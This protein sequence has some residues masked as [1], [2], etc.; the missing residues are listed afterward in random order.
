MLDAGIARLFNG[1]TRQFDIVRH[2]AAHTGDLPNA[3]TELV[4]HRTP[5]GMSTTVPLLT[6]SYRHTPCRLNTPT[7]DIAGINGRTPPCLVHARAQLLR[8]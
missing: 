2:I 1:R 8:P 6:A 7:T 3:D 5:V 4:L